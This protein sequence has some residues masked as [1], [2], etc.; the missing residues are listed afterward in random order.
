MIWEKEKMKRKKDLKMLQWDW[1]MGVIW[2][3]RE[4]G[5]Q[6]CMHGAPL[7]RKKTAY[8]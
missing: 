4:S 1:S 3:R 8:T 2:L 5:D 7:A 6:G